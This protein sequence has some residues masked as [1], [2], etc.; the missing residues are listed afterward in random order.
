MDRNISVL[1]EI[2]NE[3]KNGE[4]LT[5]NYLPLLFNTY[6]KKDSKLMPIALIER[7]YPNIFEPNLVII[8]RNK[9][10]EFIF[11]YLE[12]ALIFYGNEINQ[13]KVQNPQKFILYNR[14]SNMLLSDFD[15]L[16]LFFEREIIFL[17]NGRLK[18]FEQ[19]KDLGYIDSLCGNLIVVI[20][21]E[22]ITSTTPYSIQ[23]SIERNINGKSYYY[24]FPCVK[25][26]IYDGKGFVFEVV[27]TEERAIKKELTNDLEYLAE[28]ESYQISIKNLLR[29]GI[30][31]N[32]INYNEIISLLVA[33][34]I[35]HERGI[36]EL[37]V[38]TIFI[39][40]YN[41]LEISCY[42]SIAKNTKI[43]DEAIAKNEQ[44]K[45]DEAITKIA[46][47][48]K[49]LN[50]HEKIID[51]K[52]TKL[53]KNFK[54]LEEIFSDY[55]ITDLPMKKDTSLHFSIV[56][57]GKKI[58]NRIL[59]DIIDTIHSYFEKERKEKIIEKL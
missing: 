37:I 45:V 16:T 20:S 39:N 21:K 1:D 58:S 9:L 31:T 52:N 48:K 41:G 40:K 15:D 46:T 56:K 12:S 26:S 14:L 18:D 22:N 57:N 4:V 7:F 5:G 32:E 19:R 23:I 6:E 38:P 55:K 47:L 10:N 28:L 27:E 30:K 2:I 49:M 11:K 17:N 8:N 42:K 36:N 51:E 54:Y 53:V 34:S 44:F 25:A 13:K 24:D 50:E 33:T 29:K 59:E 35:M 3:A 43:Y